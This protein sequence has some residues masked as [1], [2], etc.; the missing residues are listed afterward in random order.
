VGQLE[1]QVALI[2]GGAR[3]QG[4]SHAV[5]LAREGADIVLLD[6]CADFASVGYPLA[7]DADLA[8]TVALVEQEDRRCLARQADVR[9]LAAVQAVVDEAM[10]DFGRIDILLANA[11][12]SAGMPIQLATAEQ[13]DEVV[14][15]NL[16]GVFHSMRAVAPIMIA[17]HYGRIVATSSMLG[18]Y[19]APAMAPY[20]ASKWGVIGLVKTVAQDL[21][22]FGVTV[23][24][25]APGNIDTPM[26]R[27]DWLAKLLR[28]DLEQP[29]L[30]DAASVLG[31]LH[32]QPDPFLP[33]AEVSAA[34][35]FLVGPGAG[36]MTG[37]VLDVSAGASARFTA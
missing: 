22:A 6:R 32:V 34:I 37:A 28:P 14:S 12:V 36:H 15:T 11:G 18:R 33:P 9:D 5:A 3:G 31:Q 8:E 30:E 13:W 20:V 24:A 26:I 2:T 35:L 7:S 27:N 4:R 23:N 10:R 1:G 16:T 19:A 17:Q 29:T 25:V 21:A